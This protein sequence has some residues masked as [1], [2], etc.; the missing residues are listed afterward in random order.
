MSAFLKS[1]PAVSDPDVSVDVR[2]ATYGTPYVH[3]TMVQPQLRRSAR[4]AYVDMGRLHFLKAH[5]Y[6][7]VY[8][9][10]SVTYSRAEWKKTVHFIVRTSDGYIAQGETYISNIDVKGM[11]YNISSPE[12]ASTYSRLLNG[13]AAALNNNAR[14][15]YYSA[16]ETL[17]EG[18]KTKNMVIGAAHSMAMALG[19][20]K[21]GKF[22]KAA[23]VLGLTSTPRGVR[24]TRKLR[25]NW[26]EYRYGWTPLLI[27]VYG[28]MKRKFDHMRNKEPIRSISSQMSSYDSERVVYNTGVTSCPTTGVSY[29]GYSFRNILNR[30][31]TC[32]VRRTAIFRIHNPTLANYTEIG[33]TNPALL[34]WEALPLSFVADWF[35]NVSD[36]LAQMD[37]W[38]GKTY[39]TGTATSFLEISGVVIP[40]VIATPGANFQPT[41][42]LPDFNSRVKKVQVKRLIVTSPPS[43]LPEFS[44]ELSPKRVVDALAL[45]RQRTG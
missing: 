34:A 36:V 25:D 26:L 21:R 6:L 28:E 40:E 39:L 41:V 27:T 38:L 14:N 23:S 11:L 31:W 17:Y 29:G 22:S 12:L 5:G 44:V 43:V 3:Q 9:Y 2:C 10:D 16:F 13:T 8:S 32:G 18:R 42:T 24:K 4:N 37:A 35:V 33:L 45:L 30:S 19:A 20:I 7:P 15:Q 1:Y